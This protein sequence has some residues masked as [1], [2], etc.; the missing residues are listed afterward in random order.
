MSDEERRK[1]IVMM[2]AELDILH[3]WFQ[4]K[5]NEDRR[6]GWRIRKRVKWNL[7]QQ[8]W[9]AMLMNK[10]EQI[11]I[12]LLEKER[13]IGIESQQRGFAENQK[14]HGENLVL[15]AS[16]ETKRSDIFKTDSLSVNASME[17]VAIETA[18]DHCFDQ[19]VFCEPEGNW[20]DCFSFHEVEFAA[21]LEEETIVEE[22]EAKE[23]ETRETAI[24]G[25][26]NTI[27]NINYVD[28]INKE[29]LLLEH[30]G[31]NCFT[32]IQNL[33]DSLS[34]DDGEL[35]DLVLTNLST[36]E[37]SGK[38]I[39]ADGEPIRDSFKIWRLGQRKM[40]GTKTRQHEEERLK[41][42]QQNRVW[43][44]GGSKSFRLVEVTL[45]QKN[46]RPH[47]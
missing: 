32:D 42:Q 9:N 13:L 29:E 28:V 17:F 40:T 12:S 5:V 21:Q 39:G 37:L 43:N 4:E 35:S 27:E 24:K 34:D 19:K 15:E 36:T 16:K 45:L 7:L 25:V 22:T 11:H 23:V 6:H 1:S 38:A 44:P 10:L 31:E 3:E 30:D 46:D 8:K 20:N 2:K 14:F 41:D 26:K 18:N 33:V 47:R